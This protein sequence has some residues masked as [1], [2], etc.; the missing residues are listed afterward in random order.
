[1][2]RR[3]SVGFLPD[4]QRAEVVFH[5][6]TLKMFSLS[7][8]MF[9]SS[10]TLQ[11]LQIVRSEL[12]PNH[13]ISGA[14]VNETGSK[15]SL[16]VY[17][18]FHVHACTPQGRLQLRRALLRPSL[19]LELLHERQRTVA[20]FLRPENTEIVKETTLVLRK[21]KNGK[22]MILQLRK[23]I[24]SSAFTRSFDSS[25]W[26]GLKNLAAQALRLREIMSN[27]KDAE[28][29]RIVQKVSQTLEL[30]GT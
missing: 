11:A 27:V 5:V 6:Q 23:G 12:H 24:D 30:T 25:V 16:S 17:G 28:E 15:E 3:R 1:M 7:D 21:V 2:H 29:I 26:G 18:L 22:S 13:Q 8:S 9:L 14:Y 10:E 4:G 20:L 19:D